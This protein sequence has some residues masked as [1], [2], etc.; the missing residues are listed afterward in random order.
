MA[1]YTGPSCRLC[2]REQNKLY[3]K[4]VRCDSPKCA[5]DRRQSVPGMHNRRK[6]KQSDYGVRLR[7]KQK[8]KRF[9]GVLEKQFRKYY[10]MAESAKGNTG[11]KMLEFFERRLDNVVFIAGWA[12]SRAQARQLVNHG[13]VWVGK[14][15]CDIA[16]YLVEQND[17]IK[18]RENEK[19]Q[20]L[21]KAMV[22]ANSGRPV[23]S[24]LER[25]EKS[26]TT[27]KVIGMPLRDDISAVV[28]EQLVVEFC[29]K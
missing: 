2:R 17:V 8:L 29:S 9:Y 13:H 14:R 5:L 7:E 26:P 16:S 24:W 10:A 3:L 15:R 22:E 1:R 12:Q 18:V 4:G 20:K 23:P 28:Q 11:A 19:T 25:D 21:I 27:F 6:G